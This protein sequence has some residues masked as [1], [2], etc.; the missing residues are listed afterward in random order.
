MLL[1]ELLKARGIRFDVLSR[2]YGRAHSWRCCWSIPQACAQQFGDEP[3]LIARR[4]Q[5]PVIV[6]EDRYRGRRL[7]E[8]EVRAAAAFAGR[9]LSAPCSGPRFRYR[10][11][12]AAGRDRSTAPGRKVA[13]TRS[14]AYAEPMHR[15]LPGGATRIVSSIGKTGMAG[16][17]GIVPKNVPREAGCILRRLRGR[18]IC[19]CNCGRPISSP[20]RRRSSAITIATL[21]KDIRELLDL[22]QR[23]G[24]E[25]SLPRKKTPSTWARNFRTLAAAVGRSFANGTRR[26]R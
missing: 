14:S 10:A 5:V 8:V 12:H 17:R 22:K 2:G 1:G 16:E 4:L 21:E 19:C 13:R 9:W 26:C 20:L 6:G 7:A 18:R 11:G 25:G 15:A 3:L 23:S 24:Q